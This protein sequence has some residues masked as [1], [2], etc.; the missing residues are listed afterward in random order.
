[1][2]T[3]TLDRRSN[4]EHHAESARHVALAILDLR[5]A[6]KEQDSNGVPM[7]GSEGGRLRQ[8]CTDKW[9]LRA[10]RQQLRE[11]GAKKARN[12]VGMHID[13]L[14]R[15]TNGLALGKFTHRNL[16]Y[17]Y[18]QSFDGR[19]I[20]KPIKWMQHYYPHADAFMGRQQIR[21]NLDR[22][23]I[24]Y[25]VTSECD[26][27]PHQDDARWLS[28]NQ[29]SLNQSAK[30]EESYGGEFFLTDR[31]IPLLLAIEEMRRNPKP[32][33]PMFGCKNNYCGI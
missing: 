21:D 25:L 3:T 9:K 4:A 10:I 32:S 13:E 33:D 1:M 19:K 30:L 27:C 14:A 5:R 7:F 26:H 23:G 6:L 28:H 8:T 2:T 15:R 29:E 22:L 18:Y 16:C 20:P 24:P 11:L 31:R 17:V 12:A